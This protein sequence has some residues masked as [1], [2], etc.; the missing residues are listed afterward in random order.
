MLVFSTP[1]VNWRPS[2]ALTISLVHLSPLPYP[3][4]NMYIVQGYVFI[5]CVT[6]GG[7]RGG[8][9]R[10]V[11]RASAGVIHYVFDKIPNLQNCF[12]TPNKNLGG[13]GASDR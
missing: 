10:A 7:G 13:E 5:Q 2:K 1:L 12:T 4:V 9:G 8:G 6:G 3:C 11:W